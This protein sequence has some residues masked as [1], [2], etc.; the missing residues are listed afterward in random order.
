MITELDEENNGKIEFYEFL[1]VYENYQ[2]IRKEE[3]EQDLV[4]AFVAMGGNSDKTGSID[5]EKL[6][7]VVRHKFEM[8]IDIE[9]LIEELDEDGNH[10]IDFHEFKR[11]LSSN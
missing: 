1:R 2:S 11:L 9:R 8:T 6:I 7:S 4:D 5:T 10:T 3:E